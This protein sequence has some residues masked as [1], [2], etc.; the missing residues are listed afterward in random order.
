MYRF[1]SAIV[2]ALVAGWP[3]FAIADP[4]AEAGREQMFREQI[5]PLLQTFCFDCHGNVESEGDLRLDT[6]GSARAVFEGR[7][8]WFKVLQKLTVKEMPPEDAEQP[9]DAER[10]F[11][12]EWIDK[13]LADIDCVREARPGRVTI[14]RLNRFEYRNTIRDL[15]GVDYKPAADFPADDVGYGFDN[16]GDVLSLPP[17]LLEKYFQAADVITKQAHVTAGSKTSLVVRKRGVEI[18]DGQGGKYAGGGKILT[19]QGEMS[20]VVEFPADGVYEVATIA[21]GHQGG[22]EP[23]KMALRFDGAMDETVNVEATESRPQLFRSLQRATRGK[24][25][26]AFAFLN[27][28]FQPNVADRNLIVHR[29]EVRG[30]LEDGYVIHESQRAQDAARAILTQFANRAFRRPATDKELDRLIKLYQLSRQHGDGFEAG[31]Q[32]ALQAVLVSPHFLFRAEADPAEVQSPR[33]LN[34]YELA[35]RLSY[36]LWSSMPDETLFSLAEKRAL[37]IDGVLEGQVLRML[38]DPKAQALVENFAGQWLNLRK[39]DQVEPDPERFPAFDEELRLAMRKET[40]LLFSEVMTRDHSVLDF[41][42]AKF[43]YVNQR[44][45]RHYGLPGIEGDQ[46]R[47]VMLPGHQRGGVLTHASILTLTSNPTRTSPVKRG[48]WILENVLGT[49]PPDPPPGVEELEEDPARVAAGSLR[50]RMEQH[51][52]K[53]I[54]A[55][56]HRLMDPLGFGFENFDAIGAWRERDGE[57]PVDATGVLPSGESFQG[58]HQLRSLLRK[59]RGKQF[60]RC[61]IEKMLTYALGRGL[62]Y[63]DQCAVDEIMKSM[64]VN[65]HRFSS[66]VYGV[67][68]SDAFLRREAPG[69]PK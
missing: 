43:T 38:R 20:T 7:K 6:F 15:L 44:L 14:R 9:T 16:I 32:F 51:R 39:L 35:T 4:A 57:F 11:F 10:R 22:N 34:D 42:D 26:L 23:V 36:F 60:C 30:P 46:F 2:A 31:V 58:P 53:P 61:L 24:H 40:E 49:P 62:E 54:C 67:V 17:V 5:Q 65:D 69:K 3:A 48:K 18:E 50:K 37:R 64:A 1:L 41:L 12:I 45:A 28:F 55:S 29:I 33:K 47:R 19:G 52:A 21:F 8:T 27:D 25:R 56:C 13:T 66:L 63:Y 59:T 68:K